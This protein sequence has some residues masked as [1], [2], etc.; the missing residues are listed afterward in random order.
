MRL[1]FAPVNTGTSRKKI[2][3]KA[4]KPKNKLNNAGRPRKLSPGVE[5]S[6]RIS[7]EKAVPTIPA[8]IEKMIYKVPIKGL[9]PWTLSSS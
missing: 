1:P 6:N 5:S 2:I 3:V 4:M 8:K 7:I 9:Y